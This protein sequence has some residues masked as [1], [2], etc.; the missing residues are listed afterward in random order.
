MRFAKKIAAV[1]AAWTALGCGGSESNSIVVVTVTA[2]LGMP[3]VTQLQVVVANAGLSDT[4]LFPPTPVAGGI[5]FD[6][7]FAVTFPTSRAGYLEV[8]IAALDA[9]SQMVA[10]GNNTVP[11]VPG[12]RA[13]VTVSLALVTN[14]DAGAPGP[15]AT[16]G[17]DAPPGPDLAKADVPGVG[18][19]LAQPGP[20]LR[21]SG[22][23][24]GTTGT[25]GTISTGGVTTIPPTGS[26]GVTSTGGSAA[27]PTGGVT[28]S[29]GIGVGGTTSTGGWTT[30]TGGA[31]GT[32]P[33]GTGG[34]PG[35]GGATG[36]DAGA[37][38]CTPA[39]TVISSGSVSQNVSLGTTGAFC[40]RTPDNISGWGCSNF[41]GRTIKVNG[42][43]ETCGALPLP[44]KVNG[45]YYF[46]VS[47][48]NYDYA[49][50]YWY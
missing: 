15:D 22:G 38:P 23:I 28:G 10:S 7:S 44:A 42:V 24:G 37:E 2:A 21:G 4:K 32:V 34:V 47:A 35:T 3:T 36:S 17:P 48:G 30:T 11:I 19:D 31:G 33:L 39:K 40:L 8:A 27:R 12:G 16:S 29:G 13:D 46:D 43:T 9:N 26:G 45:Y 41:T 14:T 18:P 20:D 6:T 50:I 1:A 49:S 25:G 5:T